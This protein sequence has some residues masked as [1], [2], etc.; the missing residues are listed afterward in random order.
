MR[1]QMGGWGAGARSA[2]EI[3]RVAAAGV[4][5]E[6][7]RKKKHDG[8]FSEAPPA[9]M[10]LSN[11]ALVEGE[12]GPTGWLECS[13]HQSRTSSRTRADAGPMMTCERAGCAAAMCAGVRRGRGAGPAAA[14]EPRRHLVV[15]PN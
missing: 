11:D 14:D 6:P 1:A 10:D 9:N 3:V 2:K 12:Q 15:L 13:E 4:V 7:L 5:L 8:Q